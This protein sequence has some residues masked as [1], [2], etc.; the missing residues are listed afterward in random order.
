MKAVNLKIFA[1][2]IFFFSF[3]NLFSQSNLSKDEKKRIHRKSKWILH[4]HAKFPS[5]LAAKLTKDLEDEESKVYAL[6]YWLAKNIKY[7]YSA[8]LSNT[9]ARHSSKEVLK[10]RKALCS[11]YAALFNEMCEAVGLKSETINGYVRDFD[12]FNLLNTPKST[13]KLFNTNLKW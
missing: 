8:Y 9:L 10:R 2:S 6:T 13:P 11:E 1:L 5:T 4:K 12:F 3:I 7:D